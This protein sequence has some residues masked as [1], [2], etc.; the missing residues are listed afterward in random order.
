MGGELTAERPTRSSSPAFG[1]NGQPIYHTNVIMC[2]GMAFAIVGMEM[3]PNKV[4]MLTARR[5][6]R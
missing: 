4:V 2:V 1:F 6:R 3:I 5:Y